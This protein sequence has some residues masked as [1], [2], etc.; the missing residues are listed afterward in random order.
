[1]AEQIPQM[2][3]LTQQVVMQQIQMVAD[4]VASLQPPAIGLKKRQSVV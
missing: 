1:M 2:A 3:A 4:Q